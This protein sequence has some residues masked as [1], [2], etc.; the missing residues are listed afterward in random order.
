MN[1][2]KAHEL[3]DDML[4]QLTEL[5]TTLSGEVAEKSV[6]NDFDKVY[7]ALLTDKWPPAINMNLVCNPD[8]DFELR[9][10]AKGVIELM[11]AEPLIGKKFLDFGCGHG[12]MP[13]EAA[14][15]GAAS[16][17]YDPVGNDT[18]NALAEEA[19]GKITG[20]YLL[21]LSDWDA[22][23]ARGPYD[24][25][26]L[27]DVLDHSEGELPSQVL[28]KVSSVLKTGGKAYVRTHPFISKH[29]IHQYFALNKAYI[30]LVFTPEELQKVLT[31]R[32][33][34]IP[35]AGVIRPIMTYKQMFDDAGL[36]IITR[37]EHKNEVAPF[38]KIP[39][40]AQRIQKNLGVKE[41]PEFQMSLSFLDYELTKL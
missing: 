18:W 21:Y 13:F 17:G 4:R 33:H 1:L 11:I 23:A 16:V 22:V 2:D 14:M 30:H 25:I 20:D 7:A 3:I 38:F 34:V 5:K 9:Q 41:F 10:R 40:I 32:T 37:R 24:V 27:F 28:Q 6:E 19:V 12:H 15:N 8:N 36:E 39:R 35:S 26:L 29:G 31:D